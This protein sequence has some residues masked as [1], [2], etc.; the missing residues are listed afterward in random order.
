MHGDLGVGVA[1]E[2]DACRLEFVA[3]GRVVLDDAVVDHRD[4]A[5][6]VPMRVGVAVGGT[7][8]RGPAGVAQP[9]L[10]LQRRRVRAGQRVVEVRQPAGAAVHRHPALAVEH[11]DA[12]RVVASVLHPAKCLHHDIAGRT[13]PD[14]ADNAAHRSTG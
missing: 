3:Q 6:A 8:V 10:A 5:G 4:L 9:G 13:L 1:V 2:L 11:G 12:R 14:V 7:A